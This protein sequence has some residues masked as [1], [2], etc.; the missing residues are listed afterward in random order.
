MYVG[1]HNEN[2]LPSFSSGTKSLLKESPQ[3]HKITC[4]K[5]HVTYMRFLQLPLPSNQ[6]SEAFIFPL[7][8]LQNHS[9]MYWNNKEC[10]LFV[11]ASLDDDIENLETCLQ[12]AKTTCLGL[13]QKLLICTIKAAH[14][15]CPFLL[16]S[17]ILTPHFRLC[18]CPLSI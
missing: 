9:N 3:L 17:P 5:H 14:R 1:E 6:I 7:D 8:K 10:Q 13:L 4:C 16:L 12:N 15:V 2:N 18:N 11:L